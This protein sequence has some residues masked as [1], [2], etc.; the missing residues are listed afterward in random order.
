MADESQSEPNTPLD[1]VLSRPP[2]Q[3]RSL[4]SRLRW[5]VT[6]RHPS[7]QIGWTQA[8]DHHLDAPLQFPAQ[9]WIRQAAVAMLAAIGVS[10]KPPAPTTQFEELGDFA[11]ASWLSSSVE[12]ITLRGLATLL[13]AALPKETAA[14][15]GMAFLEVACEN[16]EGEAPKVWQAIDTL[17]RSEKPGLDQF[18]DE[19][20]VAINP[21]A[22]ARQVTSDIQDLLRRW[23]A[24]RGLGEKRDR[25][26]KYDDYLRVWDLREGWI[27]G[28]YDN[29][30]EQSLASIAK[31]LKLPV[32][33]IHNHYRKAFEVITGHVYAPE[34]WCRL[35]GPLKLSVLF[36]AAPGPVSLH[37]PIKTRSK[38]D[39]PMTTLGANVRDMAVTSEDTAPHQIV[40]QIREMIAAGKSNQEILAELDYGPEAASAIENLRTRVDEL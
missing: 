14:T 5:E 37:R 13:V 34:R 16:K 9:Q 29:Q 31:D 27:N 18:I 1:T 28:G 24:E 12:P 30:R 36:G 4:P 11:D 7:Y 15:L 33:T 26:D 19:P 10:G 20:I 40:P 6:R 22:S 17:T 23:K 39:V 2:F 8:L 38:R 21:A 32:P 35:F 25:S 3:F